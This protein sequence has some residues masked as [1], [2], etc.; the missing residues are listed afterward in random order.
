[1][2]RLSRLCNAVRAISPQGSVVIT[3]L[4]EDNQDLWQ[5]RISIG[6]VILAETKGELDSIIEELTHKVERMSQ[7]MMARLSEVVDPPH[8]RS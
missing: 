3:E 1:M 6:G 8:S 7:R 4:P 5:G 2:E